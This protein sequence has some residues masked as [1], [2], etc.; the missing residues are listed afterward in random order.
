MAISP[1][2]GST[3]AIGRFRRVHPDSSRNE[4]IFPLDHVSVVSPSW[5]WRHGVGALVAARLPGLPLSFHEAIP[6]GVPVLPAIDRHGVLLDGAMAHGMV[7]QWITFWRRFSEN[8]QVVVLDAPGDTESL[9]AYFVAGIVG[10]TSLGEGESAISAALDDLQH[11][12]VH[13]SP[14]VIA[15]LIMV[16][17]ADLAGSPLSPRETE[18]LSLIAKDLSNQ[19][20]ADELT[21]EISTIKHH[22]HNILHK[23]EARHRWDAVRVANGQGWLD[24]P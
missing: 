11:G 14:D 7:L 20:I 2:P 22:V 8:A 12:T 18:V 23:L 19:E 10:Y 13:C 9:S 24:R 1:A 6:A 17:E 16:T 15:R 5:A 21:L 4:T 3:A